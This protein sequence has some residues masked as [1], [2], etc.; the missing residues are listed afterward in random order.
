[1]KAYTIPSYRM[2]RV[3]LSADQRAK[4]QAPYEFDLIEWLR[5]KFKF[6]T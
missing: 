5:R 1:M 6:R 2:W 3:I 4:G